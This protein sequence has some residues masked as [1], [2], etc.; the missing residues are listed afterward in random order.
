[1]QRKVFV[2]FFV[3]AKQEFVSYTFFDILENTNC[4]IK[5]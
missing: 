5:Q 1:M 2:S 3:R 4:L